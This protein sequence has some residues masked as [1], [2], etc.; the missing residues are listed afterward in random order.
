[1]VQI[2][3]TSNYDD[4][5][6]TERFFLGGGTKKPFFFL[7][8][9]SNY[10]DICYFF[11]WFSEQIMLT[12]S[13]IHNQKIISKLELIYNVMRPL[14]SERTPKDHSNHFEYIPVPCLYLEQ[15]L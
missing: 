3:L 7:I 8:I 12:F 9:Y 6:Y 1:M 14:S 13:T 4:I 5:L 11:L 15:A 2:L 10:R